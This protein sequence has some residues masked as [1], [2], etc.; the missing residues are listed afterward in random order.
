[1]KSLRT[2]QECTCMTRLHMSQH[3][4]RLRKVCM[5]KSRPSCK[6]QESKNL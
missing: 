4:N 2:L 5:M 3:N 6:F 1:M